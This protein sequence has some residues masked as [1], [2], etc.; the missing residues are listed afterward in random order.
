MDALDRQ[1]AETLALG[2]DLGVDLAPARHRIRLV[3][4]AA[5][6]DLPVLLNPHPG[7]VG[8]RLGS[9]EPDRP[10]EVAGVLL[11][12]LPFLQRAPSLTATHDLGRRDVAERVRIGLAADVQEVVGLVDDTLPI[13]AGEEVQLVV[14]G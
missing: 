10:R 12:H 14:V 2:L 8:H 5:G 4:E 13:V 7:L 11:G 1:G 3:Q 6:D 9:V